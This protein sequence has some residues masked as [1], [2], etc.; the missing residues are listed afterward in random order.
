MLIHTEEKPY[1]KSN[2]TGEEPYI[3]D[4]LIVSIIKKSPLSKKPCQTYRLKL[5]I[6]VIEKYWP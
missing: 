6:L 1:G 3:Y 5:T 4:F 2:H